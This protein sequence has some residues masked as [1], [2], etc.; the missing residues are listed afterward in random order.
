MCYVVGEKMC[1]AV[2]WLVP[3]PPSIVDSLAVPLSFQ[4][5]DMGVSHFL[6]KKKDNRLMQVYVTVLIY[7]LAFWRENLLVAG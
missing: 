6:Q 2:C 3:F 7:F 4:T 1:L 5:L